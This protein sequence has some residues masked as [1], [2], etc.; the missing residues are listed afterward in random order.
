MNH[1]LWSNILEIL[2]RKLWNKRWQRVL[3]CLAA[4]VVFG[5]T[6]ALILPAITMTKVHPTL[7]AEQT[8]AWSGDGLAV[9]VTAEAEADGGMKT[10]VLIADGEGADLSKDYSFNEEGICIITDDAGKEIELHRSIRK[11]DERTAAKAAAAKANSGKLPKVD[12]WFT[13]EAGDKVEFTLNLVDELDES[14]FAETVEALKQNTEAEKATASD[15]GKSETAAETATESNAAKVA[16]PAATVSNAVKASGSNADIAEANAL[17]KTEEEQIVTEKDEDSNFVEILD[18]AVIDDLDHSGEED[19]EQTE[20]VAKLLLSAGIG[21]DYEAAVDDAE[22]GADKR[23]DAQLMFQWKD[24]VAKKAADPSLVS[25]V[26]GATIA[27]FYD[28]K[29]GIPEG[30]ELAVEEIEEGSEEYETYLSQTKAAM[31]N[32]TASNAAKA[33]TQ[34]RFF[35]ITILDTDGNAVEPTGPVKVV[36]TY[37]NAMPLEEEDDLNVVH[38]KEEAPEVFKPASIDGGKDVEGLSFTANSFSVYGIFGM[39]TLKADYLTADGET[40]RITVNYPAEAGIPVGAELKVSE[41]REGSREYA[42]YAAD[43]ARTIY[44]EEGNAVSSLPYARFFDISILAGGEE[45]EPAAPVQVEI[46][47]KD[48]A[49]EEVKNGARFSAVHFTENGAEAVESSVQETVKFEAESFSVYGVAYTYTVD[50]FYQQAEYHLDGGNEILLSGL[51]TALGIQRKAEEAS[52]VVFS[53]PELLRVEKKGEQWNLVSIKPF[54]T[55]ETLTITFAD[56]EIIVIYVTDDIQDIQ[57]WTSQGL[58]ATCEWRIT[59]A[60]GLEIRAKAADAVLPSLDSAADW[61]WNSFRNQIKSVKFVKNGSYGKVKAAANM[62]YMLAN[63]P[64]LES[65]DFSYLYTS[66]CTGKM[67]Y[68]FSGDS[69]LTSINWGDYFNTSRVTDMSYMFNNCS[70]LATLNVSRFDVQNVK[71]MNFMFAG[72]RKLED[73]DCSNFVT[74]NLQF[75]QQI[76]GNMTSL[77]KLNIEKFTLQKV[78]G[79]AQMFSGSMKIEEF[80]LGADFHWNMDIIDKPS[81]TTNNTESSQPPRGTWIFEPSDGSGYEILTDIQIYDRTKN[82]ESTDKVAG[83]YKIYSRDTVYIDTPTTYV[84]AYGNDWEVKDA[85]TDYKLEQGMLWVKLPTEEIPQYPSNKTSKV[86][87]DKSDGNEHGKDITI[88]GSITVIYRDAVTEVESGKKYD[89][90]LVFSDITLKDALFVKDLEIPNDAWLPFYVIQ[91]KNLQLYSEKISGVSKYA[92]YHVATELINI[93]QIVV[94]QDNES[95]VEGTYVYGFNDLD[96]PRYTKVDVSNNINKT[97]REWGAS[98][99]S[100]GVILNDGYDVNTIASVPGNGL[101]QSGVKPTNIFGTHHDNNTSFEEF[102]VIVQ[103][104]GFKYTCVQPSASANGLEPGGQR[105]PITLKKVDEWDTERPV[106]GASLSTCDISTRSYGDGKL[107]LDIIDNTKREWKTTTEKPDY[108]FYPVAGKYYLYEEK[109]PVPAGY[110][111]ADPIL[112]YVDASFKIHVIKD[113]DR[114][115][116]PGSYIID[117]TAYLTPSDEDGQN[118]IVRM[119][120]P[121]VKGEL[122]IKKE[123]KYNNAI[124]STDKQKSILAGTY[125]FK[126]YTDKD[127]TKPYRKKADED[128]TVS[129]TIGEDGQ[130]KESSPIE[131]KPETYW[132]KEVANSGGIYPVEEVQKVTITSNNIGDQAVITTF[133]NNFNEIEIN[134]LKVDDSA[135]AKPLTGAAFKLTQVDENGHKVDGGIETDPQAVDK[136]GKLTFGGLVIGFYKLVETKVPDGY[137]KTGDIPVFEVKADDKAKSLVIEFSET[138]TV[139]YDSSSNI[140]KV[141]NTPGAQLPA[142]GGPGTWNYILGGSALMLGTALIYGFSRRQGERGLK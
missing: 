64:I 76:F 50:F 55:A 114:E 121:C 79:A 104:S 138:D 117:D 31:G 105:R 122:K 16:A 62:G 38:F 46:A 112:F 80:K 60:G 72:C 111:L 8:L 84:V 49:A 26:N 27:V 132:I 78:T 18:G 95:P 48:G 7:A 88:P 131:M 128:V 65:V 24:V 141:I 29:A 124:P 70:S 57:E 52:E 3:T 123:V 77:K 137:V 1:D 125:V 22:K 47:L 59:D 12:Y 15:A 25:Y 136:N 51:F 129:I 101:E 66:D 81:D 5:V 13:L 74:S 23:G 109:E 43:A 89:M 71:N 133:T 39:G 56:G 97:N 93:E 4:V 142:T 11:E 126:V 134:I 99:Y 10:F 113:Y 116:V 37:D 115:N 69:N 2:K 6:Y 58:N 118:G 61:P 17:A 35:D 21:S 44:G 92:L 94:D 103:A 87:I 139:I 9:K 33:V 30:A 96:I 120:D 73:L 32:A 20:I 108:T 91:S 86:T 42:R 41:I 110:K 90:K 53:D 98:F 135:P 106:V 67:R 36:I 119:A 34:A 82:S 75:C 63:C 85:T 40:Y 140:Y 28:E 130:A 100:E 54:L 102:L 68:L 45:I 107:K 127:C 14:R 83:T 19:E